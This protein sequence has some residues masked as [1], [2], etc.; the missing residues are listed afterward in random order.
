MKLYYNP[1]NKLYCIYNNYNYIVYTYDFKYVTT[2]TDIC[3]IQD[4]GLM[5]YNFKNVLDL[6]EI[7]YKGFSKNHTI[8]D[9]HK[10]RHYKRRTVD[11]VLCDNNFVEVIEF[12]PKKSIIYSEYIDNPDDYFKYCTLVN[13]SYDYYGLFDYNILHFKDFR[14]M[15]KDGI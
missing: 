8:N 14:E 13:T 5:Y 12:N 9:I 2:Y 4:Y 7:D 6:L 11:Y 3:Q 15:I 10:Y 1:K